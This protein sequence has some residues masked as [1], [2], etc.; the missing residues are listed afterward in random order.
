MKSTQITNSFFN[1]RICS[2]EIETLHLSEIGL[3]TRHVDEKKF[4]DISGSERLLM[5]LNEL[6]V[7]A[8]DSLIAAISF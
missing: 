3:L 7:T 5:F 2:N 1:Q 8:K 4:C 6:K